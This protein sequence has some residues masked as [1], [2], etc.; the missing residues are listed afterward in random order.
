MSSQLPSTS[1]TYHN[2]MTEVGIGNNGG[3][4]QNRN[5]QCGTWMQQ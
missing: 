1:K 3:F 4:T 2:S 5:E